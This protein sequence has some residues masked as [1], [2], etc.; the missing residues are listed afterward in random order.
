[1]SDERPLTVVVAEDDA[2][3]RL[4]IQDAFRES[5]ARHDLR[6]VEDGQ[7]LLDYLRQE[8]IYAAP[9]RAPRPDLVLLDLAMPRVDGH[10]ALEAIRG[11]AALRRIPVVVLATTAEQEA[12][13]RAYRLGANSFITKPMTYR[14]LV[15]G[16]RTL[17]AYW[18]GLVRR[19]PSESGI[20]P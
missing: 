4:M 18:G 7:A 5:G 8:G 16:I 12:V 2:D 10:A 1:M 13:A 14:A 9:G 11:D 19:P 15:E 6:F 17:D 3:D 20:F